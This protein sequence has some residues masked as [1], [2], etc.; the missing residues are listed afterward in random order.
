MVVQSENKMWS[1]LFFLMSQDL[2][3][4][5]SAFISDALHPFSLTSR[6]SCRFSSCV[7]LLRW[8]N[9]ILCPEWIP[10][11]PRSKT[12]LPARVCVCSCSAFPAEWRLCESTSGGKKW[13]CCLHL[14]SHIATWGFCSAVGRE[15]ARVHRIRALSHGDQ[16]PSA[17]TNPP[18]KEPTPRGSGETAIIVFEREKETS[19][20]SRSSHSLVVRE[21]L[22][23]SLCVCFRFPVLLPRML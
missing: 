5:R 15:H 7:W 16:T 8:D 21:A 11:W 17:W 4:A 22:F 13:A 6:C 2:I 10:W 14:A 1:L 20:V 19:N 18:D 3:L 12:S 9:G 23:L